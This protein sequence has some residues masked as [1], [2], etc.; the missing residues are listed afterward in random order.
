M[1]ICGSL[2]FLW[3]AESSGKVLEG[4]KS[5]AR[6]NPPQACVSVFT[7]VHQRFAEWFL[8]LGMFFMSWRWLH[9]LF[10]VFFLFWLLLLSV[11]CCSWSS[12]S[13]QMALWKCMHSCIFVLFQPI[14]HVLSTH[15]KTLTVW[16]L[17]SSEMYLSVLHACVS[18]SVSAREQQPFLVWLVM[19]ARVVNML[20]LR[21]ACLC[22]IEH[23]WISTIFWSPLV[24]Q[25]PTI[26][27]QSPKDY[28]ID[29][30]ENII[31][32]CEAKGKPHPR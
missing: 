21:K 15:R 14:R 8:F 28:I 12:F 19:T 31:I 29:P 25:P 26:T 20:Q 1:W 4:C 22:N 23:Y 18:F 10:V 11:C 9:T 17:K 13:S 32:H 3:F 2:D 30:R 6:V 5:P 16:S 24:P 27:H 7:A